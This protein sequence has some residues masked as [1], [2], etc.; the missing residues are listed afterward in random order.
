M[1][2][3]LPTAQNRNYVTKGSC[4]FKILLAGY[5]PSLCFTTLKKKKDIDIHKATG[6]MKHLN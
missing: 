1:L 2:C 4:E 3:L 6:N 5:H